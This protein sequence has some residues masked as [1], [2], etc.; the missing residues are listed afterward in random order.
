M[1]NGWI[2][3]Y[4]VTTMDQR[5]NFLCQLGISTGMG[6]FTIC[7]SFQLGHFPLLYTSNVHMCIDK[8]QQK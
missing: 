6:I 2:Q 8:I 3:D 4:D 7:A 5:Q 1:K